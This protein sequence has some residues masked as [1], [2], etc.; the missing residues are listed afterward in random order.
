MAKKYYAPRDQSIIVVGDGKA[1][2]EQLKAYGE[3]E[4][5]EK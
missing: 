4:R 2:A 5:R 3:F 1:V